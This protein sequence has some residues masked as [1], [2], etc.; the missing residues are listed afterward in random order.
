VIRSDFLSFSPR[1][2]F[3]MSS[4]D[5]SELVDDRTKVEDLFLPENSTKDIM[6]LP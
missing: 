1:Y 4:S 3:V 2:T 5:L 6:C